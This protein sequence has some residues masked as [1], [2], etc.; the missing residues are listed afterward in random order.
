MTGRVSVAIVGAGP[1]GLSL[2]AHLRQRGGH[3]FGTPMR[4][5]RESMPTGMLLRSAWDETSLSA[6]GRRGSIS[7][8]SRETGEPRVEPIPL[9]AFLRYSEWFR[10]TYVGDLDEAEV[11]EVERTDDGSFRLTTSR[12]DVVGADRLV[13]AVGVLPF[14]HVPT[15]L[16]ALLGEGVELATRMPAAELLRD[17]DV[18]VVGGGQ[19]ALETAVVAVRAGAR[20]QLITRSQIHWFADREPH[21]RRSRLGKR[22]YRLAYPAVGYGPPPLNRLVLHPDLYARLPKSLRSRLTRRLLRPGASPWLRDVVDRSVTLRVGNSVREVDRTEGRLRLRLE[23]GT[24][25]Q[26]DRVLVATGYRFSLDGVS[27]LAPSLRSR[28][29]TEDGWPVLDRHFRS[30]TEPRIFMVGYAAEGRFG[31]MSRYVLGTD[32]AANRVRE[33]VAA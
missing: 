11:V 33:C 22:L 5:W 18:A 15:E 17:R 19:S 27:F 1:F 23:D 7:E 20:V 3:V 28:I 24:T 14:Q 30:V 9:D 8:W 4:T 25:T 13:L 10:D 2:G 16:R 12:G 26:V 32:F 21:K 29:A 31:P 6:P